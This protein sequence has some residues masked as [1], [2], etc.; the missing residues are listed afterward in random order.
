MIRAG[1]LSTVLEGNHTP[2]TTQASLWGLAC[3]KLEVWQLRASQKSA[4]A[5]RRKISFSVNGLICAGFAP[6]GGLCTNPKGAFMRQLA[7]A[8]PQLPGFDSPK[9]YAAWPVWSGSTTAEIKWP[10]VI[11]AAVIDWYHKARNWNAAKQ[12]AGRYGGTL[13][14]SAL[15]VLECLAFDFQNYRSGRC[16]PSYEGI[17]AK[18]GLGR[19]TVWAAL[20]RLKQLGVIHWQ[21]RCVEDTDEAGRFR[22]RQKTNAYMLLPPSQWHGIEH[23]PEAPLPD[24][25]TW[26]DHPPLPSV[27]EQAVDDRKSGGSLNA[28]LTVLEQDE[29]DELAAACA[30]LFRQVEAQEKA[31][32][33]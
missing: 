7:Y 28:A 22:L 10:K 30:R 25:G 29:T 6:S 19:S 11:K 9:T 12:I 23:P 1:V 8:L 16:D 5:S 31:G 13:G 33:T 18:T 21:Q 3:G 15:R 32:E 27:M 14:S 24:P 20:A 4:F 26:G 17:A 2:E